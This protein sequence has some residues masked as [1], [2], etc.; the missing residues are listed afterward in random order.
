LF[1]FFFKGTFRKCFLVF[2]FS[3]TLYRLQHCTYENT[4]STV[5]LFFQSHFTVLPPF[6]THFPPP[7]QTGVGFSNL[8]GPYTDNIRNIS[9]QKRHKSGKK[10][11][12]KQTSA[13]GKCPLFFLSQWAACAKS[14]NR[15]QKKADNQFCAA[16]CAA[17]R[18]S[19]FFVYIHWYHIGRFV[20]LA[21]TR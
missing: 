9:T 15:T 16:F 21:T 7:G 13:F 17:F 6:I 12:Q 18:M 2:L 8:L 14:G 1:K 19:T 10:R 20:A 11:I 3:D 4:K 5:L